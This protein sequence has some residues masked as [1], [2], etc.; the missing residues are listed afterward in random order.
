MM[1]LLRGD[2]HMFRDEALDVEFRLQSFVLPC[3]TR[4]LTD[5]A[6]DA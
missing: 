5:V 1:R 6:L 3:V 2:V 4:P